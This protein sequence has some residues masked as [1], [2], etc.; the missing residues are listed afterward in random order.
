MTYVSPDEIIELR[1]AKIEALKSELA[2]LRA[3]SAPQWIPFA[4]RKPE[5]GHEIVVLLA[6]SLIVILRAAYTNLTAAYGLLETIS[7]LAGSPTGSPPT[8]RGN[9]WGFG[10]ED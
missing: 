5:V 7:S 9:D 10:D 1:E 4:E 8:L 3:A 6:T 2:A